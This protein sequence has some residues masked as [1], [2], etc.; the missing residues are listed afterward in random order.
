MV[1]VCMEKGA[2]A[3]DNRL[4]GV[5]M[6]LLVRTLAPCNKRIT[7]SCNSQCAVIIQEAQGESDVVISRPHTYGMHAGQN[8]NRE[9]QHQENLEHRNA[10]TPDLTTICELLRIRK[11]SAAS[12]KMRYLD[13][14]VL[15]FG[16]TRHTSF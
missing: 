16:R 12:A 3:G 15:A 6:R 1:F 4:N 7:H 2:G 14:G 9:R 13:T 8:R 5:M 11:E 10:A